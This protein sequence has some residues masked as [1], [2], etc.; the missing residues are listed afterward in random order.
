M[1]WTLRS[2]VPRRVRSRLRQSK[3]CVFIEQQAARKKI[4]RGA[5][6]SMK[7]PVFAALIDSLP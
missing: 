7:R 6:V 2:D 1:A 5:G 4:T 3:K